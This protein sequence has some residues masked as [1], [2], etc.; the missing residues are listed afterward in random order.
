MGEAEGLVC[1][2]SLNVCEIC[3]SREGSAGGAAGGQ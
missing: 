1:I 3:G 2:R